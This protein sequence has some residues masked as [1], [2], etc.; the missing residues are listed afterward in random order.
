MVAGGTR[1]QE[2]IPF[3]QFRDNLIK[4]ESGLV[5]IQIG[6]YLIPWIRFTV[7]I[8]RGVQIIKREVLASVSLLEGFSDLYSGFCCNFGSRGMFGSTARSSSE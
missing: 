4:L 6:E 3:L 2:L 1:I 5:C 7:R 8:E